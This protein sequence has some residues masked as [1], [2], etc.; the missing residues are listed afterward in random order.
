MTVKPGLSPD[1]LRQIQDAERMQAL[2]HDL[3]FNSVM[4]MLKECVD[5]AH[6]EL[7]RN[8]NPRLDAWYKHI[9]LERKKM[10]DAINTYID[11]VT[12]KRRDAVAEL[13][14]ELGVPEDR[15]A[16]NLDLSFQDLSFLN[17]EASNGNQSR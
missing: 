9:W 14:R 15:I 17:P 13:L 12:Q 3:S 11:L 5:A 2:R 7:E 6:T 1:Q 16:R 4:G 8:E 10:L